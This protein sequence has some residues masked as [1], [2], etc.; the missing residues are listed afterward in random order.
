MLGNENSVHPIGMPW[1][2]FDAHV[3]VC[4]N[5]AKAKKVLAESQRRMNIEPGAIWERSAIA[6]KTYA[7][8]RHLQAVFKERNT[9]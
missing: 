2:D 4:P 7:I 3:W 9:P 5:L 1:M 6:L 8:G